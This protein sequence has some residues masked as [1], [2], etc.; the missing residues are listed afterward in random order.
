MKDLHRLVRVHRGNDLCNDSEISIEEFAKTPAV[1]DRA[2]A[3]TPRDKEF[4]SRH[5]E[6]VLYVDC[7]QCNPNSVFCC[8]LQTVKPGPVRGLHSEIL[9]RD[10][11]D[12]LCRFRREVR[13]NRKVGMYHVRPKV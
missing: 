13:R 3:G 2:S 9:I 8:G 1:I 4:K 5:A 6:R 12:S 10:A 7:Q 11:I